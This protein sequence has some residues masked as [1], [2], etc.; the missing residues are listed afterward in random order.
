MQEAPGPFFRRK[1]NGPPSFLI[2]EDDTGHNPIPFGAPD[3]D[4]DWDIFRGIM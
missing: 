4:V 3:N 2:T 1:P